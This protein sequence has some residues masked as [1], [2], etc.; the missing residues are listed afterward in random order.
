MSAVP[1]GPRAVLVGP[2]GSGKST[3]ARH[4]A[5]LLGVAWRDTDEDVERT[6]GKE[7]SAIFFDEGEPHF[8]ALERAAVVTAL[9]EHDGVLALGGGAVLDAATQEALGAYRDAGGTVV[10]LDVSLA[11]AAPRVG[12][13]RA[14]PLLLGNPR[15]QWQALMDAR[16][17]VYSSVATMH[18]LTDDVAPQD[19][20][21]T[22]AAALEGPTRD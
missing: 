10:F 15:A 14:R 2:P 22:I 9:T 6:A 7:I 16:R 5:A 19:V 18:V 8:R 17:P 21:A 13:Q 11:H 12:F 4:L 20:A 1:A 3:V